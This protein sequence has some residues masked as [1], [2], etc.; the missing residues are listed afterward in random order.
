MEEDSMRKH[1]WGMTCLGLAASFGLVAG[2]GLTQDVTPVVITGEH[3][4][5]I[6][7]PLFPFS[8]VPVK[9]YEGEQ[10]DP[11]TGE[12]IAIRVEERVLPETKTIDGVETMV[13]EAKDIEDGELIER[14]HDYYAQS[15]DG[16]VYYLGEDVDD[17]EDGEVVGHDGAWLAG[18]G[19][20]Q[21]GVFMLPDPRVGDVFEQER[22]PGIAEDRSTVLEVNLSLSTPAGD[23][24]GCMKT[25]DVN[26]IDGETEFKFYC[27]GVGLVREESENSHLDLVS[28]EEAGQSTPAA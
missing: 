20:N 11:E 15:S 13:V 9:I 22:A 27:P 5:E 21:P 18:E 3:T 16:T 19:E 25:E 6:T 10:T 7:N 1:Q 2:G 26:P 28:Y 17:Y 23:F 4:A 24:T 12:T 14:T 8:T